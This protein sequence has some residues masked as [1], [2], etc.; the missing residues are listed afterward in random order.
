MRLRWHVSF[1]ACASRRQFLG[2]EIVDRDGGGDRLARAAASCAASASLIRPCA[3]ALSMSRTRALR[4]RSR[5]GVARDR[6]LEGALE[7]RD[8]LVAV[9]VED[10][11]GEAVARRRRLEQD[12]GAGLASARSDGPRRRGP[13]GSMQEAQQ[14]RHR[15]V[16]EIGEDLVEARLDGGEARS[17]CT[18]PPAADRPSWR[19][20]SSQ[21]LSTAESR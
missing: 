12:V 14:P 13:N 19:P 8:A 20:S 15:P 9:A 10:I 4:M 11:D 1:E 18:M 3:R 6:E 21:R 17:P 16:R 7:P 5:N 2:R